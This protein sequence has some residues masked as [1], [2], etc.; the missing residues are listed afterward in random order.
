MNV[1]GG[2]DTT[3]S[4]M[5]HIPKQEGFGTD[6]NVEAGWPKGIEEHAR[7][8]PVSRTVLH[9]RDLVRIRFQ[10]PLD[11][12]KRDG[13]VSHR[14]NVI[15]VHT[16][17]SVSHAIEDFSKAPVKTIVSQILV[18]KRGQHQHARAAQLDGPRAQ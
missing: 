1:C 2:A 9:P 11:N 16:E 4:P 6:K 3:A 7:I 14:R 17:A 12:A 18:V 10:E 5:A 8:V 15:E 13:H